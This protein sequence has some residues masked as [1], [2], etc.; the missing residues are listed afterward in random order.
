MSKKHFIKLADMIRDIQA[1]HIAAHPT[2]L[3]RS[4]G[5]C[6]LATVREELARVLAEDNP[7]FNKQRWLA[8]IAGDCGP[9]GGK[10]KV[11]R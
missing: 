3:I 1:R 9:N 10:V 6:M 7:R 5:G 8:Y 4:S 11:A 2:A